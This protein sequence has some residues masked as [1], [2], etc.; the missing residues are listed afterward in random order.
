MQETTTD[1]TTPLV[2]SKVDEG[3]NDKSATCLTNHDCKHYADK[4]TQTPVLS[5]ECLSPIEYESMTETP[6]Q[7][8]ESSTV[9]SQAPLP[10][11]DYLSPLEYESMIEKPH[12]CSE[13]STVRSQMPLPFDKYLSSL[14]YESMTGKPYQCTE[15]ST[16]CNQ[17][18][19]PFDDYL[20]PLK[21]ESTTGKP[22]QCSENSTEMIECSETSVELSHQ[23]I[24][25][26]MDPGFLVYRCDN[27]GK[28]TNVHNVDHTINDITVISLAGLQH[29]S[30]YDESANRITNERSNPIGPLDHT[31]QISVPSDKHLSKLECESITARAQQCTEGFPCKSGHCLVTASTTPQEIDCTLLVSCPGYGFWPNSKMIDKQTIAVLDYKTAE[32]DEKTLYNYQSYE[33]SCLWRGK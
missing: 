18:P 13:S 17:T 5:D 30:E 12:Q 9:C 16:V 27:A 15:S 24:S 22:N 8:S 20:S 23:A 10:F 11:D 4:S 28:K 2:V 14:R 19:I 21:Y 7:C 3:K 32:C 26:K 31:T 29:K 25:R 33:V 6:Y 1:N